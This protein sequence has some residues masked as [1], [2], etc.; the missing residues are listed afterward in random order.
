MHIDEHLRWSV[1]TVKPAW[2]VSA[3]TAKTVFADRYGRLLRTWAGAGARFMLSLQ[4]TERRP[5]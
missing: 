5:S 4:Q 1:S 2:R 3:P